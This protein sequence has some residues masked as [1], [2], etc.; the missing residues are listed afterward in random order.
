MEIPIRTQKGATL[1]VTEIEKMQFRSFPTPFNFDENPCAFLTSMR[2]HALKKSIGFVQQIDR[3]VC[4]PGG[5][6][7]RNA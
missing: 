6:F 4:D 1:W 3:Q 5:G 7:G 2:L